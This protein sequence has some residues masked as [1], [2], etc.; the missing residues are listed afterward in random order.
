MAGR[1]ALVGEELPPGAVRAAGIGIVDQRAGPGEV[2]L[3]QR[4]GG[5]GPEGGG[6]LAPHGALPVAEEEQLVLLDRSTESAPE[7]VEDVLRSL[8]PQEEEVAGLQGAVGVELVEAAVIIVRSGLDRDADRR[9]ARHSLLG[10]EAVG[11]DVH[12]LDRL[13]RRHV[14]DDVRQPGVADRRAVHARVVVGTRDAVEVGH[15]GALRVARVGVRVRGRARARNQLV[16]LLEVAPGGDRQVGHLGGL[17]LR[18][19]FGAVGLEPGRLAGDRHALG[20]LADLQVG[21]DAHDGVGIDGDPFL[22]DGAERGRGNRQ[23]VG[24]G[25]QV[26]E[27]IGAAIVGDGLLGDSRPGVQRLDSGARHGAARRVGDVARQGAVED[28]RRGRA[29]QDHAEN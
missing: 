26:R 15:Q 28:L 18:A 24:A 10:V 13:G 19:H 21:V 17:E 5:N 2:P 9:A 14:G 20:D 22:D 7:L 3:A 1:D 12:G 6:V 11:D 27:E 29:A 16:E 23:L 8:I 4:V 25:L